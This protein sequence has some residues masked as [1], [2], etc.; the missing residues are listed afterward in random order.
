MPAADDRPQESQEVPVVA[1]EAPTAPVDQIPPT[2]RHSGVSIALRRAL[3]ERSAKIGIVI[4]LAFLLAA[5]LAGV[6]APYSPTEMNVPLRKPG[7]PGHILGTDALGRDVLSIMLF[8]ARVSLTFAFLAAGISLVMGIVLGAVP[9]F[10]GGKFDDISA[11]VYEVVLMIPQLFLII[12]IVVLVGS[13]VWLVVA[14]VGLTIWPSNAKIM[15][16]QVLTI[17]NALFV[18]AALASGRSRLSTLF[19]HVAPNAVGAVIANSTLQMA[20]AVLLEAGLAFLGL[21]DPNT[22]SWGLL[23]N[24]GQN[25]IGSAPW[26]IITPGIALTILLVGLHLIGDAVAAYLDPR[27]SAI[28]DVAS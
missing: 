24:Q 12:T 13:N 19:T 3:R 15:R 18:D 8:G 22:H 25:Y 20:E 28:L 5:V 1:S 16:A 2:Q 27:G 4:V 7:T 17:R 10:F 14:L 26:L 6:L 9:A 21:S 23:L 11:R